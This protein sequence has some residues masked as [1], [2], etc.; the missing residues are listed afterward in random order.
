MPNIPTA[1]TV[2][3][4]G[5]SPAVGMAGMASTGIG[6]TKVRYAARP[7]GDAADDAARLAHLSQTRAKRA[8]HPEYPAEGA[9]ARG[10]AVAP[11]HRNRRGPRGP[12]RF[13]REGRYSSKTAGQ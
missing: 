5:A 9:G 3:L 1:R 11:G 12:R 7:G 8:E 6:L 13:S 10:L 4:C 2:L